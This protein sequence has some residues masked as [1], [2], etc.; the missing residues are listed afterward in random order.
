MT[1]IDEDNTFGPPVIPS[2]EIVFDKKRDYIGG[3]SFG[4]VYRANCRGKNVA[5]K[6]PTKQELTEEEMKRFTREIMIMKKI[7]HPNI[8]LCLGAC[9]ETGHLMVVMEMMK[10]SLEQVIH[11]KV[12]GRISLHQKLLWARDTALGMNWLHGIC[13]LVHRDLKPAN[14][15]LDEN[16][17]VKV[18]DFGFSESL[19]KQSGLRD[20]AAPKGTV[21]YMAPEIMKQKEFNEKVDVY[22]FGLILYELITEEEPYLEFDEIAPFYQAVCNDNVRPTI[23]KNIS[24]TLQNLMENCWSQF[25]DVRPSFDDV[26]KDVEISIIQNGLT[27]KKCRDFWLKHFSEP[28]QDTISWHKLSEVLFETLNMPYIADVENIICK[29]QRPGNES[30]VI[31]FDSFQTF[32][33]WFGPFFQVENGIGC[34]VMEE[35]NAVV[36]STW[37][38]QDISMEMAEKRLYGKENGTFLVRLSFKDPLRNPFTLS[39]ISNKQFVH[40]RISRISFDPNASKRYSVPA[41]NTMVTS[42]SLMGLIDNLIAINNITKPCDYMEYDRGY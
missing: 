30:K 24:Q 7:F 36:T 28:F 5:V 19:K 6:I 42:S 26:V 8:V 31:S 27:D 3:G 20:M 11:E 10:I 23:P 22:S 21:L 38:H 12:M 15:M 2:S 33:S 29:P 32:Y 39:R 4:K 9:L 41:G 35:I 17:H 40:K 1:D 14:L 16:F 25:P 18:T 13:K 37:F 34:T